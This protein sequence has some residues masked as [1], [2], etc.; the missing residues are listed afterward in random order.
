MTLKV[1]L[2]S[3][4]IVV[5]RDCVKCRIVSFDQRRELIDLW[6]GDGVLQNLG[7]NCA[8]SAP[9]APSR[10]MPATLCEYWLYKRHG[11]HHI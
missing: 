7:D 4:E 3:L 2:W 9:R 8:V 5:F 6:L 1:M 11:V 10:V